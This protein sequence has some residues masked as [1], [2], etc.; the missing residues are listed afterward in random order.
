MQHT[1]TAHI[2]PNCRA[3]G[4][5]YKYYETLT[6]L[7]PF[8]SCS[9][10]LPP[11]FSRYR[12]LVF[13]L[14]H[15]HVFFFLRFALSPMAV[16]LCT[17]QQLSSSSLLSRGAF[18]PPTVPTRFCRRLGVIRTELWTVV[19]DLPPPPPLNRFC[20]SSVSYFLLFSLFED[21]HCQASFFRCTMAVPSLPLSLSL[22]V[23]LNI[24]CHGRVKK[25][26]YA[27]FISEFNKGFFDSDSVYLRIFFEKGNSIFLW[28]CLVV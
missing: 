23:F 4:V 25:H 2:R 20:S 6:F 28:A 22:C 18:L 12:S 13:F 19:R 8:S 10:T 9:V 15:D 21:V 26:D 7:L 14:S 24:L 27:F 16:Q 3:E 17:P 1:H 5:G 11:S